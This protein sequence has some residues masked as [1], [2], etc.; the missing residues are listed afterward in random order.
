MI[1]ANDIVNIIEGICELQEH[2]T[3]GRLL[4]EDEFDILAYLRDLHG[5]EN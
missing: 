3:K 2:P 1:T 5:S 4:T